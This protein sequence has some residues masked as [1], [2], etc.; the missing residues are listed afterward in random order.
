MVI[1]ID[2]E[3]P[4]IQH[5]FVIKGPKKHRPGVLYFNIIKTIYDNPT[6]AHTRPGRA[7]I[8]DCPHS[9]AVKTTFFL[10]YKLPSLINFCCSSNKWTEASVYLWS[11][12]AAVLGS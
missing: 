6:A 9:R 2:A 5:P 3:N 7:L 12:A 4:N 1:L 10:E 11:A 8:L